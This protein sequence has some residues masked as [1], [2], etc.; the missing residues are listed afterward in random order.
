M[1]AAMAAT[2]PPEDPPGMRGRVFFS[3]TVPLLVVRP[4]RLM[5][6]FTTITSPAS[7]GNWS[8]QA[9]IASNVCAAARAPSAPMVMK[10]FRDVR[11]ST[12]SSSVLT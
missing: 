5:L 10:A 12:R 3:A 6:S 2:V 8:P 4:C 11:R 7:G 9:R 1:R